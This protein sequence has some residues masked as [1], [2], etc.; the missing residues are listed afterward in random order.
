MKGITVE[1]IQKTRPKGTEGSFTHFLD[2]TFYKIS[3]YDA[4]P[5]FFMTIV[6]SSDVWN[7]LWSNGGITAGRINSDHA[8]FPYYTADKV[9]DDRTYTGPYTAVKVHTGDSVYFWEPFADSSRGMWNVERN[10]FKNTSGSKVYFEEINKNL[11]ITF[12][13]G[14]MSSDEYGL[15]R[16]SRII[17]NTESIQKIDILD[18]CRN[19]LPACIDSGTQNNMSVLLDAYKKADL[20]TESGIAVFALS[21]ILCDRAEPSESLF[22]N[23]GWFSCQGDLHLSS[24]TEEAFRFNEELPADTIVK[25][26]RPSFFIHKE[27]E[28]SAGESGAVEWYQVFN[29]SVDM[30]AIVALRKKI[31]NRTEAAKN[32][33]NNIA[34]GVKQL[35]K[36]IAE[37]DGMQDTADRETCVHH[38]ANV[39]FNIM[40]GGIFAENDQIEIAD[41]LSFITLRN[42]PLLPVF[43]KTVA[44]LGDK[45]RYAVLHKAVSASANPQMDRLFLEYMP[46]T[47]SRR[48]GDPSRPW[49]KF[50]IELKDTQG[51][52][53]L[54]Y[55]GNWRDIF[56]NWEA[57]AL[58]YPQFL[59]NMIAKFLNATTPDGFNPYRI[60]REGIDWETEEP[61]N[62][63][64][65]IGYWG[66]HQII[67]LAKLLELQ[68]RYNH[69]QLISNL[70]R[71]CYSSG[72]IPYRLKSYADIVKNPRST[73][74]FDHKLHKK[75]EDN[76]AMF[77]S[78][79]KLVQTKEGQV[80][81]ISL[82]EKFSPLSAQKWRTLYPAAGS[83]SIPSARNGT[84]QITRLQG[85]VY[86]W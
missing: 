5:A 72:N 69:A 27:L 23:T 41:F 60:T 24:A 9:S 81:L 11:G 19:I 17:N 10:I 84:T 79:A 68:N 65:N 7:Y 22:A 37:A 32:L 51:N 49:N 42:R 56:Q 25:G 1:Q 77:G 8:I 38:E 73:I 86:P 48:H 36:Y 39:M 6:S 78:D 31:A 2:E 64:S 15:V 46:L 83:G 52:R 50:A 40:R 55:Q 59:E 34:S 29:T 71:T 67:Y 80:A 53:L 16:H 13:Y 44:Q 62:Q 43:Q 3:N 70:N 20:E 57:L 58:S 76:V 82:T 63:F 26:V 21:S 35:E 47:F 66:D 74:V 4:M 18:G 85:M 30:T 45:V 12:Q 28:L 75:I 33:K 14:W 54:N 61:E